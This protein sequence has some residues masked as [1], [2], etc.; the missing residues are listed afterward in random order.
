MKKFIFILFILV[1]F[2][3][4]VMAFNDLEAEYIVNELKE[5]LPM[6]NI[7]V[8]NAENDPNEFLGRP[9]QYI[10]KA[11]WKDS[12]FE[13][14]GGTVE[15]FKDNKDLQNRKEYLESVFEEYPTYLQYIYVH[16]NAILRVD[17][18][19]TPD[20]AEEYKLNLDKL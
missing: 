19:L 8:F 1:L 6:T 4:N 20:Q 15:V 16:K 10:G 11:S 13:D 5:E 18:N 12:R 17:K 9:G 14:A 3:S 7:K 2:T